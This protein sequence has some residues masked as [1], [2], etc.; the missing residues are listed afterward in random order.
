MTRQKAEFTIGQA[1]EDIVHLRRCVDSVSRFNFHLFKKTKW[2]VLSHH[3]KFN[4][5]Q[6]ENKCPCNHHPLVSLLRAS[7]YSHTSTILWRYKK[8]GTDATE[9]LGT[10]TMFLN[11]LTQQNKVFRFFYSQPLSRVLLCHAC[12]RARV[13]PAAEW[14]PQTHSR[15]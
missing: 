11:R 12:V 3:P 15:L 8:D 5:W 14:P 1:S 6:Y 10:Y 2:G 9:M 7:H 13:S 4:A